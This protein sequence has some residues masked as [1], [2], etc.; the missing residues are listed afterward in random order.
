LVNILGS[1][2]ILAGWIA[3]VYSSFYEEEL[4]DIVNEFFGLDGNF[5]EEWSATLIMTVV[6]YLIPYILGKLKVFS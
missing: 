5:F 4:G 3:I 1:F 2:F 6:G